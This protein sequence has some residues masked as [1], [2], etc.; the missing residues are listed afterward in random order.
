MEWLLSHPDDE[1]EETLE[2]SVKTANDSQTE[3][4]QQSTDKAPSAA[5]PE[6]SGSSEM[7]TQSTDKSDEAKSLKCD[8]CGRLFKSQLEMEFHASKFMNLHY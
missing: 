1:M 7:E 8:D 3:Q 5:I 6:P 4:Q 2:M